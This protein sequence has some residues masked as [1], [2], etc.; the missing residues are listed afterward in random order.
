M[1]MTKLLANPRRLIYVGLALMLFGWLVPLFTVLD[2][3]APS[4][5]L[6]LGS[7]AAALA[8]F[9]LGLIGV[10]THFPRPGR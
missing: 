6:L 4:F 10:F 1:L 9:V 7:Y 2:V 8:G 3:I 5:L